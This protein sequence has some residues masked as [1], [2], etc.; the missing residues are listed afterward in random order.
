MFLNMVD[1]E[2]RH[3]L[4]MFLKNMVKVRDRRGPPSGSLQNPEVARAIARSR[5]DEFTKSYDDKI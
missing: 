4:K 3:V 2:A 1:N 5:E